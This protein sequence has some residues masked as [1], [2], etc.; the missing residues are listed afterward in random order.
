MPSGGPTVAKAYVAIIP[1][2]QGAQ[3]AIADGFLP[4]AEKAGLGAGATGGEALT[5]SMSATIKKGAVK[6]AGAI[7]AIGVGKAFVDLTKGALDAYSSMEQLTGGIETIFGEES[8]RRVEAL[9]STAFKRVQM[10]ANDYMAT[11]TSFSAS[12]IQSLGGDTE[13]AVGVADIALTD[14]ADNANKMG[15]SIGSIQDAYRGFSR[16]VFTM[17]DNLALGYQGNQAEMLRLVHDAGVVD[18]AITDISQVSFADM[19]QGIHIIQERMGIAGASMDEAATTLEGSTNMMRAS[20][21]DWLATIATGDMSAIQRVTE[22]L[23]ESVMAWLSNL[24]PRIAVIL[25]SLVTL[26]P[27]A[28]GEVA[29]GFPEMAAD[30][31]DQF[32]GAMSRTNIDASVLAGPLSRIFDTSV[33]QA[34]AGVAGRVREAFSQ[35]FGDIDVGAAFESITSAGRDVLSVLGD[36]A[37]RAGDVIAGFLDSLDTDRIAAFLQS[38]RDFGEAALPRVQEALALVGRVIAE[39]IWPAVQAAWGFI[40]TTIWPALQTIWAA[41]APALAAAGELIGAFVDSF[42]S[43]ASGILDFI[44]P[45][46]SVLWEIIEPELSWI[47]DMAAKIISAFL[48]VVAKIDAAIAP[49]VKATGE[50]IGR[51]F[52]SLGQWITEHRE[53]ISRAISYVRGIIQAVITTTIGIFTGA[54]RAIASVIGDVV[55]RVASAIP[56]IISGF[57]WLRDTISWIWHQIS[58]FITGAISTAWGYVS[59]AVGWMSNA[60]WG[61]VNGISYAFSTLASAITAPFRGAFNSIRSL[62]NSTIGGFS[63]TIPSWIPAVGGSSFRIPYLAEGGDIM[64]A[65]SV[66]VGEAGPELLSLPRGARVSPL[67]EGS[68]TTE[69]SY[70]V[71]VGD[72]D[73]SDDDQVR[74]VTREYLEYLV[75]V[76]RPVSVARA[77]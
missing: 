39:V 12:L 1:T 26:L 64:A 66:I 38:I 30:L 29:K 57:S 63:F 37:E 68:E 67:A 56:G 53:Q 65:G 21:E 10:S 7:A 76:S 23:G 31:W 72:V 22:N 25:G 27:E 46:L 50:M 51:M 61:L 40:S 54:G 74:R 69:T 62:W 77:F 32:T 19:I 75:G 59:G 33:G 14:M 71:I 15:T 9:A 45:A 44:V 49:F 16:G 17:L 42:L 41:A 28:I 55:G 34:I 36:V 35:V 43:I 58:G 24:L 47:V 4:A 3:K 18:E 73:L 2:T 52:S 13:A 70:Q 20:W 60:F 48:G 5:E 8:G 6:V 11:V